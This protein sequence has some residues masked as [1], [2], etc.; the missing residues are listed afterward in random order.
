MMKAPTPSIEMLMNLYLLTRNDRSTVD[1]PAPERNLIPNIT[2]YP[3]SKMWTVELTTADTCS[4]QGTWVAHR[5]ISNIAPLFPI[6]T[7]SLPWLGCGPAP[8][9]RS[10]HFGEG[11]I[12]FDMFQRSDSSIFSRSFFD[13]GY[14]ILVFFSFGV[15]NK[16]RE[17]GPELVG[18]SQGWATLLVTW[19]AA[20]D[21]LLLEEFSACFLVGLAFS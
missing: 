4:S 18:L 13:I 17:S 7:A 3:C 5:E 9:L 20:T 6:A 14:W 15:G 21:R 1:I 2:R 16:S 11:L 12:S 10:L 8:D 19:S